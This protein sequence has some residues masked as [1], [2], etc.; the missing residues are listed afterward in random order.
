[1][2]VCMYFCQLTVRS[3]GINKVYIHLPLPQLSSLYSVYEV[4]S[5]DYKIYD[6]STEK[7]QH[8]YNLQWGWAEMQTSW[9]QWM[10]RKWS[11]PGHKQ[12]KH[13]NWQN[14]RAAAMTTEIRN[15]GKWVQ[16]SRTSENYMCCCSERREPKAAIHAQLVL[17]VVVNLTDKHI[18]P[19]M[20]WIMAACA[21]TIPDR[22]W[23]L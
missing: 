22:D 11:W 8:V 9:Y 12:R 16:E 19:R 10:H 5:F 20:I 3:N 14:R 17:S 21:V 15:A 1:M 23:F 4:N 7:Y 13:R 2:N 18:L 6:S